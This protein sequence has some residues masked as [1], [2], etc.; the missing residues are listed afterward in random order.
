MPRDIPGSTY[1]LQLTGEFGFDA[2][3]SLIP[4]L[5]QLGIT[6]LYA[7]PF[8]KARKG[9]T[10]GYD[11][12]D[13]N[14]LN[15]EFG[16]LEAFERLS[17]ALAKADIGLILDFVPNH[18]GVG[19]SDN[20]W[21]L[22]VLEWG[23]RSPYAQFFDIDW[24]TLPYK[25][26]GGV[27][28]PILGD[29]YGD[30]LES[31][32]IKL[33]YDPADGSFSAWYYEHRLP[34]R[35]NRYG[36]MLRTIVAASGASAESAA[37]QLLQI[38]DR[39]PDPREPS[40]DQAPRLKADL[41][42]VT[43]AADI[44]ER[45]L[46][47]YRP[48]KSD[49]ARVAALH[50]LLERQHYR[51]AHWR[52]AGSE[53]NYRRF[54]DVNDLAGIR[55]EDTK[56]FTAVHRLVGEMIAGNRLHGL[57]LDH[58][59]GLQDPIAYC[60]RLQTLA[61]RARGGSKRKPFYILVEKILGEGEALPEFPGVAGTTGYEWL[62]VISQT[63][64]D[65]A[66]LPAL[67]ELAK[68]ITG[69]RQ[70]FAEVVDEAKRRVLHSILSSEFVVLTRLLSR[71][72]AGHW[73][74]RD[75]TL[76]GL[77]NAL[78]LYVLCFPVYRTYVNNDGASPRDRATIALAIAEARARWFGPESGIFDFLQDALTLD[79]IG[80]DRQGYSKARVRRFA[81]KVQQFTGPM[82][83]KSLEDTAFYR[84]FTLLALNEVG[85]DPTAPALSAAAFH[86]MMTE[87]LQTQPHGMTGTATHDTK[88]GE[89]AR[90]RLLAL[91][92]LVND[93]RSEVEEWRRHNLPA[94]MTSGKKRTPSAGHEYMFYQTMLGAWPL[95]GPDKQFISRM[96]GYAIKAA[97]EGKLETSWLNPDEDYEKGFT[98]FVAAIL[99]DQAFRRR[100]EPFAGK[101]ALLGAL[102]SLA[103]V[104]LKAMMPGVPDFYQGT[105][106][107]DLSL[108]DPDNRRRV[109]FA[110]RK[111]A[112]DRLA[113]GVDW[114]DLV[115]RWQ[116]GTIKLALTRRLLALRNELPGLFAEKNYTPLDV[117]GVDA[118]HVVA[119]SRSQAD[120][121]VVVAVG[122]YF[123]RATGSGTRW[124]ATFDWDA[125]I[126]LPACFDVE[127][128]LRG[129]RFAAGEV[130]RAAQ[131]F[132]HIP[133]AVLVAS[134]TSKP[135]RAGAT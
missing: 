83:A 72:A 29:T 62:N 25:P 135:R 131:L 15:P 50:R 68:D 85:G 41:A 126:T 40:R 7:S 118:E 49:P 9:S 63:L 27:L 125:S 3:A 110:Q 46:S 14:Q 96:Q 28:L 35:P 92:E 30:V 5:K 51:L 119:F 109:D 33:S 39:Y 38:A 12:V 20:L 113:S 56:T 44:L 124:P 43:G 65:P 34:I 60:R 66:G 74:T 101:V 52:V 10:H 123:S 89:D 97:R 132:E 37:E 129:K 16:G 8:L 24:E 121:V 91:S 133:V 58:I 17:D 108:V 13:H 98:D 128:A 112:L 103:Q 105:E 45:G 120:R 22:D 4:Y 77:R 88:R 122:R 87:R 2:A 48:D 82:M 18:M 75:F 73:R 19:R 117:A 23:P 53:I 106:M 111:T 94:V 127:D 47:A 104:T 116:D 84:Y 61:Q 114:Q 78:E 95:E 69:R 102:N 90:A 42:A 115:S 59:D 93:W 1:R 31:G 99:S 130:I 86:G 79:L 134:T 21:W 32:D 81:L 107:W 70:P 80:P 67:K 57:R 55:V 76:D 26:E 100:V 54:F 36:E 64:V 71:I 11:I 6:H